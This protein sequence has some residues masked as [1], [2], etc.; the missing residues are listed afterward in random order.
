MI[1]RTFKAIGKRFNYISEYR[2]YNRSEVKNTSA[3]FDGL[4][5]QLSAESKLLI[6]GNGPSLRETDFDK[7]SEFK[8]LTTNRAYMKWA[9]LGISTPYLHLSINDLVIE[10]FSEDLASLPCPT[11]LNF[12]A[13]RRSGIKSSS[14]LGLLLLG[15]FTGDRLAPSITKPFSSGGT[16]TFV[17]LNLGL[18]LGFKEIVLVGVDH[19][20]ASKGEPNK[21]IEQKGEDANHFFPNYFPQGMKWELPDLKRSEQSYR[22]VKNAADTRGITIRDE[23]VNGK[24]QVFE[25]R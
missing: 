16:V 24:L 20:F 7:Y 8:V 15:F 11:L 21:T 3:V 10:Q 2:D 22:I 23:T 25:K 5:S 19:S 12:R 17:A 14:I 6:V 18:I 1:S 9:D 4:R 13:A